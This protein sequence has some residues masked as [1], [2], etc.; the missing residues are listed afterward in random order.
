MTRRYASALRA[1][2]SETVRNRILAALAEQLAAGAADFSL[3]QVAQR[4]GVS[5]RTVH[6][7]FPGEETRIAALAKWIDDQVGLSGEAPAS[8]DDIGPYARRMA[9]GHF[10]NEP[11]MRAQLAVGIA[12]RVRR[13]RR[14]R[15]EEQ[16]RH[17]VASV[18]PDPRKA[19]LVAAMIACVISSDIA[20][21]LGDRYGVKDEDAVRLI[22]WAARVLAQAASRGD[23]PSDV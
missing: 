8:F 11:L 15:R 21:A 23:L 3:S 19:E 7:Y 13:R 9:V 12:N 22:E 6:N 20:T 17:V 14:A 2:L 5:L 1:E 10:R 18:V 16:L 4:A